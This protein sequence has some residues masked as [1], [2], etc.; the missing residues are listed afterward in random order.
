MNE[1]E[2]E[3]LAIEG[4]ITSWN[5]EQRTVTMPIDELAELL[6]EITEAH[7]AYGRSL[8]VIKRLSER[9]LTLDI[10][11]GLQRSTEEDYEE[12]VIE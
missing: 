4:K 6:T 8:L 12:K 3:G 1:E 10:R 5:M 2:I 11:Y 9:V 7:A